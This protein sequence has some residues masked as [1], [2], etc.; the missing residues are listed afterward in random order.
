MTHAQPSFDDRENYKSDDEDQLRG[1]NQD[2]STGE[3]ELW[4]NVGGLQIM[5]DARHFEIL[6]FRFHRSE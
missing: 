5:G 2:R 3:E 1:E 4:V 6:P